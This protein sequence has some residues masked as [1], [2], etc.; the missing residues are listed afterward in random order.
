MIKIILFVHYRRQ[1]PRNF[2]VAIN[3]KDAV[4]SSIKS[5]YKIPQWS[6][7]AEY[8][9]NIIRGNIAESR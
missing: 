4:Q 3:A 5:L 6:K 8:P 7:I 1:L 2:H 9:S